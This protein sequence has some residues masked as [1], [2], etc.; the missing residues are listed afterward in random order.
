[1]EFVKNKHWFSVYDL[2]HIIFFIKFPLRIMFRT[3]K[4]SSATLLFKQVWNQNLIRH[5]MASNCPKFKMVEQWMPS[6]SFYVD[7]HVLFYVWFSIFVQ[8]IKICYDAHFPVLF[9]KKHRN[10]SNI[11]FVLCVFFICYLKLLVCV[12]VCFIFF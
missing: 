1:V 12:C 5:W 6:S 11:I 2:N 8:P 4:S 9:R 7:F 3:Q 10:K